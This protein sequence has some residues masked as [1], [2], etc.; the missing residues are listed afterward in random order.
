ME[1]EFTSA[2][3]YVKE[4][5]RNMWVSSRREGEAIRKSRKG[6][7]VRGS[8]TNQSCQPE[9]ERSPSLK[10]GDKFWT[11]SLSVEIHPPGAA[12]PKQVLFSFLGISLD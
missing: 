9:R 6:K 12:N 10:C 4:E 5:E 1:R 11:G 7:D 2:T 3:W 8:W